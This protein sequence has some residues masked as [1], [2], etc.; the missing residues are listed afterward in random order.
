MRLQGNAG[1]RSEDALKAMIRGCIGLCS[2]GN[3]NPLVGFKQ[4]N[5]RINLCLTLP[6]GV[7]IMAR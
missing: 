5:Y 1:T 4:W 6:D 2:M 3:G 7:R